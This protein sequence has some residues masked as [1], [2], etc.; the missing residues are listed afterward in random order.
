M[1]IQHIIAFLLASY[2]EVMFFSKLVKVSF[3]HTK[4]R[5]FLR[6]RDYF[7]RENADKPF[8]T[9]TILRKSVESL[10]S[11]IFHAFTFVS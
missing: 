1:W 4:K 8:R 7:P 11:L 2:A 5:D 6:L 3:T 10:E 9:H